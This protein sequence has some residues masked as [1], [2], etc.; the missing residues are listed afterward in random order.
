M[1]AYRRH[2]EDLMEASHAT[3]PSVTEA[4]RAGRHFLRLSLSE[5]RWTVT[6][7]DVAHQ[8]W[9]MSRAA[10]WEAGVREADRLDR[11]GSR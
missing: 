7:D 3:K 4:F 6:V 10:A 9:Y 8:T 2:P 1:H 5:G 11:V